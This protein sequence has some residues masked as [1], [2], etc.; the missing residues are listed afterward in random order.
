[1]FSHEQKQRE[2]LTAR[3]QNLSNT[4]GITASPTHGSAQ[5]WPRDYLVKILACGLRLQFYLQ[6]AFSGS[7]NW[8]IERNGNAGE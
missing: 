1:M 2:D 7:Q 5:F 3:L 4:N 6:I 8:G